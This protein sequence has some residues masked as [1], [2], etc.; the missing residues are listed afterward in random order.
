MGIAAPAPVM[1]GFDGTLPEG[2]ALPVSS[3]WLRV[4][5]AEQTQPVREGAAHV[6]FRLGLEAGA[7]QI[8]TWWFDAEGNRLAGAHYMTA[9]RLRA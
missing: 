1:Q 2:K 8:R 6:T 5:N 7:A 3:A 4:G 9:E